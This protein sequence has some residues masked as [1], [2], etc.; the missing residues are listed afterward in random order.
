MVWVQHI[1]MRVGEWA[2]AEEWP[3][4]VLGAWCIYLHGWWLWCQLPK[5]PGEPVAD[6]VQPD[7]HNR[8]AKQHGQGNGSRS[9][10]KRSEQ[11]KCP[12]CPDAAD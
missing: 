11:E 3:V 6:D 8:Q 1:A 7:E 9:D 2:L 5:Q 4:Y 10:G 12:Y